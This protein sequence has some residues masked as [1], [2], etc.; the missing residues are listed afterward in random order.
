[1]TISRELIRLNDERHWWTVGSQPAVD[2]VPSADPVHGFGP[3][4]GYVYQ[5]AFVEFF[6]TEAD[7]KRIEERAA[8][9]EAR[10]RSSGEGEEGNIKYFAGNAKGER[11][12]N[13]A[14]GD[15]NAVTWGVFNARDIVTTTL[16]EEMS[17]DAWRAEA[18]EVWNDWASVYPVN[19]PSRAL[20]QEVASTHWLVSVC[21]HDYK[22]ETALWR[23]L[24]DEDS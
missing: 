23:W 4:G 20:L 5:K 22:D 10:R 17:F 18:F 12:S 11:R 13:M 9:E 3:R 8:A 1:M 21:H 6:V 2:G 19:S 24:L 16:I 15:V 7:L 14:D